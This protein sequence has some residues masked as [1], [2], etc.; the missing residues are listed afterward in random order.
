MIKAGKNEKDR[1]REKR[2]RDIDRKESERNK[3]IEK[4]HFYKETN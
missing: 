3:K 4:G 2:D 1:K